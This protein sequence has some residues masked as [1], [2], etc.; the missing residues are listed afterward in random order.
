MTADLVLWDTDHEGSFG[1]APDL[2]PRQVWRQG[3][4]SQKPARA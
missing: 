4:I 1:W 2:R 3:E